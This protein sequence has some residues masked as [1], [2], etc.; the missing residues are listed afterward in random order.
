MVGIM[1][2]FTAI[3]KLCIAPT[4]RYHSSSIQSQSRVLITPLAHRQT[5]STTPSQLVCFDPMWNNQPFAVIVIAVV[6]GD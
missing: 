1:L 5:R 3:M 2:L 4:W 6:G